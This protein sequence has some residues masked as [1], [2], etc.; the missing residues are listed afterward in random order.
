MNIT[1][2]RPSST[3]TYRPATVPDEIARLIAYG[4]TDDDCD[5]WMGTL[6]NGYGVIRVKIAGQTGTTRPIQVHRFIYEIVTGQAIPG[7][8]NGEPVELDHKCREP[9]CTRVTHLEP[10]AKSTNL[11]RRVFGGGQ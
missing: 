5:L 10:V 2:K 11:E 4:A 7:R 1:M 9:R 6:R 8:M 3:L